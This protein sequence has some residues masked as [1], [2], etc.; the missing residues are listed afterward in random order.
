M[1]NLDITLAVRLE[2]PGQ[3]QV[4]VGHVCL[5]VCL[6]VCLFISLAKQ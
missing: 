2:A 4:M 6:P 1:M 5:S 3:E